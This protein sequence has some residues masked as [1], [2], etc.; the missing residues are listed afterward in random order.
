MARGVP[1]RRR[2]I[3][4]RARS[5]SGLDVADAFARDK[6]SDGLNHPEISEPGKHG[7]DHGIGGLVPVPDKGSL[8]G[9]HSWRSMIDSASPKDAGVAQG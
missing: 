3:I 6:G 7:L 9:L 2:R 5:V 1:R 8:T 4:V